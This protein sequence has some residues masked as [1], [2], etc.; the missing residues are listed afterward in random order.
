MKIKE[1]RCDQFAGLRDRAYRFEDGLNLIIGE[2]ESGKSTLVDLLYHLFFQGAKVGAKTT[3]DKSFA[4]LYFPKT[5]GAI[6]GDVIDGTIRFETDDGVY[7]LVKEWSGNGSVKLT[8]PDGAVVR[9]A[10]VISKTLSGLLGYGKGVYDELVFASQRRP[11][12]LLAGLLGG[13][14]SENVTELASEITKA[15]METGGIQID[16][17]EKALQEKVGAYPGKWDFANCMPEGG[18]KRG[19]DNP[20]IKGMGSI[21]KAYYEKEKIESARKNAEKAERAVEEINENVRIKK[22]EKKEA[23]DKAERFSRVRSLIVGKNLNQKL[24][25]K[26]EDELR[27]L[28]EDLEAWPRCDADFQK[29]EKLKRELHQAEI[30]EK[31]DAANGQ[32]EEQEKERKSLAEIGEICEEDVERS[33]TLTRDIERAENRLKGLNL[34][35]QIRQ[36]SDIEVQVKSAASGET[37]ALDG[38]A[39]DITEAVTISV[40]G[41]VEIQLA[42]KG[43]DVN[44]I[45]NALDEKRTELSGLLSRYGVD[46]AEELKQQLVKRKERLRNVEDLNRKINVILGESS[47]EQLRAEAESIHEAV[48]GKAEIKEDIL[49]LC[50][51]DLEAYLGRMGGE[52][53]RYKQ[54]YSDME[55]LSEQAANKQKTV[56]DIKSKIENAETIPEEFVQVTDADAF[57]K[58]LKS[59]SEKLDVELEELLK[60]AGDIT[61]PEKSAEDYAEEYEKADGLFR[62][63]LEEYKHWKHIQDTFTEVKNDLRGNPLED[64]EQ[65]FAEN[66]SFLSEGRIALNGISEDLGSMISS[67]QTKLSANILSDGTK[68][69]IALAFR[70]AMLKHLFPEGGCIA[71]FDDPF[72]DMDPRRTLQACKLLQRFAEKNQVLF[73]SCDDKYTDYLNGHV[74]PV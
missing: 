49:C 23:S 24:L 47:W 57:E 33:D 38:G 67:G 74:I 13:K 7:K 64:V 71:V 29:A 60:Q 44:G 20:W 73:I 68:D 4:E 30:R 25:D 69:T 48:R 9:D 62:Q 56:L 50:K 72:T 32:I 16:R 63:Q 1:I 3:G 18:K 10:A 52:I 26:E 6:Q 54:Q 42:P 15:V 2:N 34:R 43:V 5:V 12:S 55:K 21:V 51:R 40:P 65:A 58:T 28:Q 11:Q 59:N 35:A 46:R 36:L 61:T 37:L 17:I 53:D 27:Q 31:Y 39:I 45:Q 41:L 14:S 66:L 22:R 19:I 70:L 8:T